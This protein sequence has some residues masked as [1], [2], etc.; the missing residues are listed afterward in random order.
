MN[1][2]TEFLP[3]LVPLVIAELVL[4][5]YTLHHILTHKSY[6]RGNRTL[7]LIVVIVGMQFIGPILYFLLGKED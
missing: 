2:I 1:N 4:L 6:K 7:W 3:F 5:A